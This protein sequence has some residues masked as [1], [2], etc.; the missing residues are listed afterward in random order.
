MSKRVGL[1][2]IGAH[3]GVSTTVVV[4]LAAL[5]LKLVD[6]C[7]LV[8]QLE[9]FSDLDLIDWNQIVMGGHEIRKTDSRTEAFLL[10]GTTPAI[11]RELVIQCETELTHV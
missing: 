5:K 2:L 9:Q 4:G 1:W 7:G 3:G 11:S 6:D 10:S 8:S